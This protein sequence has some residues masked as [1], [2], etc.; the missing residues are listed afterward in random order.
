MA[1]S[2]DGTTR[3]GKVGSTSRAFAGRMSHAHDLA[4]RHLAKVVES[5]DDAIVSKDL[6]GVDRVVEPRRR[7][8]VRLHGGGDD[9]PV[10]PRDHPGRSATGRGRRPRRHPARRR[11]RRTSKPC[12]GA[13]TARPIDDLA[14]RVAD[15]DDAGEVI[16]ASKIA[17]D[18]S[19]RPAARSATRGGS[20]PSSSRATTPSSA[21]TSHGIVTSWNRPPSGCSATPRPRWSASRSGCSS[22]TT[23]SRRKTRSCRASARGEQVDH[24]ET[25]RQRKDGGR[26]TV[27]LTVSPIRDEDG[28]DRRRVEDRPRHH[29]AARTTPRTER[30]RCWPSRPATPTVSRTSSSRR[31]RT[32]CG[33]RST[34]S[35]ATSGCCSGGLLTGEK[36][37]RGLETVERNATWLTPDRRGRA[38]RLAHRLGQAPPRRPAGGAAAGDRQN[39][40][41]TVRPAADAK[42]VR[43]VRRSSIR[44]VGPVSGDPERLQQVLWNLLS[45]AV[46]FTPRGGRV[47]VRL[48]RVNSHVEII[49]QRHR[50]RHPGRVPAPRVRALPAGRCRHR[51]AKRGGLG[52][53]L[54]IVRHLVELHGGS[55][56]AASDGENAGAPSGSSCR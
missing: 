31:C 33:R 53:G 55:V 45:N 2:L 47:Q 8:A 20:R 23:G 1:R 56:D 10:D 22:P 4:H 9:R 17:R 26:V 40:V 18:I 13:R 51:R 28:D 30:Q 37:T 3:A 32:S 39:A 48:E 49:G 52:L 14:D 44:G 50:R 15:P 25:I 34:R 41:E 19:A 27:S 35:S 11:G 46:K 12:G 36:R 43:I 16:G 7:A 54:A 21:R 24:Y 42:G 5:S 29:R 6:D 38:R